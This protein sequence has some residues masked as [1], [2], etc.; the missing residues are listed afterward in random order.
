[1]VVAFV[2]AALAFALGACQG[3]RHGAT[4]DGVG[5]A[6]RSPS[7][8]A[9]ATLR[10][11]LLS[12]FAGALEPCGCTKDQ[13]GGLAHFGAWARGWAAKDGDKSEELVAAAGPF[14]F[15]NNRRDEE[16]ADQ[17]AAKA[18]TIARVL[19]DLHL[20][21][22]A[23]GT[24]DWAD[25]RDTLAKL[26][27][28]AGAAA[29]VASPSG[30][31]FAAHVVR[32]F[33]GGAL[34][35][36]FVGFGQNPDAPVGAP[37]PEAAVRAGVERAKGE[38]ANVI[39][40]LAAVGRGEAKRIADSVPDLAV[41]VVGSA[42]AEGDANTEPPPV[43]RVGDVLIV[44]TA[45]HLQDVA[46][47]DLTVRN[48]A[49]TSRG[50]LLRFADASGLELASQRDELTRRIDELH[51][52]IAAW[53]RD[54]S[55]R[56][57]D[58]A[59]RRHELAELEARRDALDVRP[60]PPAGNF[61]RYSL[62]E[63]RESL[64]TDPS[65]EEAMRAYYKAVDDHNRVEFAGRLPP[66]AAPGQATYIGVDACSSCHVQ[67]RQV[68]NG[69]KHAHA[70]ASLSSQFKE[71]NLDCVSCHVTGYEQPGGSTVTHVDKLE[72][73]QC[74]VCHG[75]GSR[76][77]QS[78]ADP[79]LI[80]ANPP[81]ATCLSCHHPPHVE[82]FDPAAKLTAILGPGHGLPSR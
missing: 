48:P 43:E 67:P 3:C 72:N 24:N 40:A 18:E 79:S 35:V 47:L 56:A 23:P 32:S 76:H 19:R 68:W 25:G 39:I 20:V 33:V 78:P 9:P 44:Q 57:S 73:V 11:F 36:G 71:F 13:L 65:I 74:E 52:R 29:I 69:T 80:V 82:G 64:G 6:A 63:I 49:E 4:G 21:A 2:L 59:A 14:F 28:N 81:L 46:V 27:E 55:V 75:P 7:S 30:A 45:N 16:H 17:D 66:P 34:R 38:G 37:G 31:P 51:V 70:Y 58:V 50:G 77:A 41:V 12:D 26:A 54:Q 22:F 5:P 15:M 8:E 61:F 60:A 62:K 1:M 10:L 42:K 53:E